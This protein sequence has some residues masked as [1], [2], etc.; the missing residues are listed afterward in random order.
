LHSRDIGLYETM[1]RIPEMFSYTKFLYGREFT[2]WFHGLQDG[3]QGIRTQ[4]GSQLILIL[5][6]KLLL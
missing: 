4:E 2:T 6:Y 1:K 5:I 3:I